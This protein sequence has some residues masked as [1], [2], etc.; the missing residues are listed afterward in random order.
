[1]QQNVQANID[2]VAS[3]IETLA[4]YNSFPENPGVSRQLF[5][6][7]ELEARSYVKERMRAIG[8]SV[9]EDAIGNIYGVLEGTDPSLAPVWSGSHIDTVLSGG[10]YDGIV[11]VVGA[12]EACRIIREN[13]IPHARSIVVLVFTSEE[14]GRF[15]MGCIGSRAMAGHLPLEKTKELHDD[16]G[17]SL[18]QELERLGYTKLDYNKTVL[19]HRGDVFASVELHIEQASM[20]EEAG[21][22]VGIVQAICAPT[23][24]CVSI[25]GQQKHAGS[26]PMDVR[27]DAL[28]AASE[29]IL[30]VEKLARSYQNKHTVA[31]VGKIQVLPN[32]SNVI[33]GQVDFMIDIRDIDEAVKT[34]LTQKFHDAIRSITAA[35]HLEY[36]FDVTTDDLPCSCDEAIL[37]AIADS[38][39]KRGLPEFK[40]TS[41]AYH[42]SLLIS[43]FTP[44]GMIFVPSKDG[45]SHN[46][47]E[48]TSMEEIVCGVNVLTDTLIALSNRETPS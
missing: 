42:D 25:T 34:E 32:S 20:L 31:T 48:Y 18:Y 28:C 6:D 21:Y 23:Y 7:A 14:C 33:P 8:M 3:D 27:K 30:T 10:K 47:D 5:T 24:I 38:C 16:A 1:M 13:N 46:P 2:R 19:K 37:D 43:E 12:L 36:S 26:T 35:R 40:M 29:V 22:P 45:V 44:I 4:T 11:G 41:G 15:G 39:R 17:I 9:H